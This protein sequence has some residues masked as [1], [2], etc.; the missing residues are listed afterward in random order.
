M[1]RNR[2]EKPDHPKN[3]VAEKRSQRYI[4]RLSTDANKHLPMPPEIKAFLEA[5]MAATTTFN[6]VN[7]ECA[8][9]I[10]DTFGLDDDFN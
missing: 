7:V 1:R 5:G 8:I 10:E 2:L 4:L 6:G 9:E 3:V